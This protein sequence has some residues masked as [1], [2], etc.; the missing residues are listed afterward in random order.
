MKTALVIKDLSAPTDLD[1]KETALRPER[2]KSIIGGRSAVVTVDGR[3]TGTV[4][5]FGLNCA[6]FEGHVGGPMIN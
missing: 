3:S 2:M 5:E 1:R 6:I 4:D